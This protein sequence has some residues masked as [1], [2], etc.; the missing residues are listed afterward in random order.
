MKKRFIYGLITGIA[1]L[2]AS[3]TADNIQKLDFDVQLRNSASD[4]HVGDEVVFDFS[5]DPDY[6]V[7]WSG[8]DGHKYEN[9]NRTKVKVDELSLSYS[10][11]QRYGRPQTNNCVSILISEDFSGTYTKEGIEVATWTLLSQRD[12][13]EKDWWVPSGDQNPAYATQGDLNEYKD[14]RF[15]LAFRYETP[16]VLAEGVQ[17]PRVDI[18]PVSLNKTADGKVVKSVNPETDMGFR[19]V[20][21]AGESYLGSGTAVDATTIRFQCANVATDYAK[22]IDV[23]CI[24]LPIDASSVASDKGEP[25]RS[26]TVPSDSYTHIFEEAGTYTVTFVARNANAWNSTET[27]REIVVE[28]KD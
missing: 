20:K 22:Y 10:I 12:D 27:V 4:V 19:H 14:K 8:E 26:M 16:G 21:V 3:C 24:S 23:W 13:K 5:G 11:L 18:T 28:V 25:I 17:H 9:R 6:I 2:S 7:F 1:F 15:Y